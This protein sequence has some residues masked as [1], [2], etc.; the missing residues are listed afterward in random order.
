[1]IRILKSCV[2]VILSIACGACAVVIGDGT[3]LR[4]GSDAFA[5]YVESVF[6]QQNEVLS[7]LAFAL[8]AEEPDSTRYVALEQSEAEVLEHCEGLNA[9]ATARQRGERVGGL[10]ALGT[11]RRA[12]ECA[13]VAETARALLDSGR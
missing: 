10:S 1:M 11:A 9:L 3:R 13:R 5:D 2:M 6:R 4:P 8:D 7:A 12:P